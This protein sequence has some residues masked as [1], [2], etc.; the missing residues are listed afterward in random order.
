LSLSLLLL[1]SVSVVD[2]GVA[3]MSG[4]SDE[5]TCNHLSSFMKTFGNEW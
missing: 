5:H 2:G 1:S 3:A 4:V